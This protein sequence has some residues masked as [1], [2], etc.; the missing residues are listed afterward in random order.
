[1]SRLCRLDNIMRFLIPD[2]EG[3]IEKQIILGLQ[4][5][6]Q[7]AFGCFFY[8]YGS[9]ND[10][11]LIGRMIEEKEAEVILGFADDVNSSLLKISGEYDIPLIIWHLDAPYDYFFPERRHNY[12]YVYHF[13]MDRYYVDIL[14]QLGYEKVAY[15]PLGTTPEVF[16]PVEQCKADSEVGLVGNLQI[17]RAKN[18]WDSITEAWKGKDEDIIL[19][20]KLIDVACEHG[21]DVP[22]TVQVLMQ[23]GLDLYLSL[24][25][26]DFLET[27]AVQYRR[28]KPAEALCDL[29]QIRVVGNDWEYTGVHTHQICAKLNYYKEL[30]DFYRS[31]MINLNV[32]EPQIKSGLNQ[33]FFDIPACNSFLISDRNPEICNIFVPGEEIIVYDDIPDLIDKVRYYLDH[34]VERERIVTAARDKVL[35]C[36][37]IKHRMEEM[38]R[39]L[40]PGNE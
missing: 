35:K 29:F 25:I 26:V 33:R 38:L 14:R 16:R 1:M 40:K 22:T 24:R 30:P 18:V 11:E 34:P 32:T 2:A 13:C 21:I 12:R 9:D 10:K 8:P 17:V 36:H 31:S 19:I 7:E 23:K 20:K 28:R 4:E 5:A 6:G 37:T 15:L 3:I 27:F 39:L